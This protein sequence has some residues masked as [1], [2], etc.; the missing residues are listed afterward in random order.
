MY[1][2][3]TNIHLKA[4]VETAKIW[5]NSEYIQNAFDNLWDVFS[6]IH[7]LNPINK[8][9]VIANMA[10]LIPESESA[11]SVLYHEDKPDLLST[12]IALGKAISQLPDTKVRAFLNLLHSKLLLKLAKEATETRDKN[13]CI[14]NTIEKIA[15][16]YKYLPT[17]AEQLFNELPREIREITKDSQ[18]VTMCLMRKAELTKTVEDAELLYKH[19]ESITTPS[20]GK[21]EKKEEKRFRFAEKSCKTIFN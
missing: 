18:Y 4:D 6:H 10:R 3:Y 19:Y 16:A 8:K 15:A 11:L 5:Q 1:E 2:F 9:T 13:N 12:S 14:H 20:E 7:L 17:A 21:E